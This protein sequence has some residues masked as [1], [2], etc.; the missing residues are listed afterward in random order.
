M[1]TFPQKETISAVRGKTALR[2]S[3]GGSETNQLKT[4]KPQSP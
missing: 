3:S 4:E 1:A 2:G